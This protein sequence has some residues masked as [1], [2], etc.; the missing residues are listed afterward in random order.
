LFKQV[1]FVVSKRNEIGFELS[2]GNCPKTPPVSLPQTI[3]Y[4]EKKGSPRV[5]FYFLSQIKT[6]QKKTFFLSCPDHTSTDAVVGLMVAVAT[7]TEATLESVR[8]T[9][10]C[11]P[12]WAFLVC[13]VSH[14]NRAS[15]NTFRPSI[16]SQFAATMG[17]DDGT[18]IIKRVPKLKKLLTSSMRVTR[19]TRGS[20]AEPPKA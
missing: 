20:Q 10:L 8:N 4:P 6:K 13:S 19:V 17:S 3:I 14:C 18:T 5:N 7:A 16:I 9:I 2:A 11:P 12:R 1:F 15:G